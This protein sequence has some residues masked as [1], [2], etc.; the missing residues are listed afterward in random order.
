MN[1]IVIISLVIAVVVVGGLIWRWYSPQ[2]KQQVISAPKPPVVHQSPARH[3]AS[4]GTYFLL[5]RVALTTD[6]GVVCFAPGTKVNFAVRHDS[7][8]T[9]TVGEHKFD[10]A[11]SQLTNDLDIAA[12]VAKADYTAQVQISEL[13]ATQARQYAQQQRDAIAALEKENA[14]L[15]R[16]HRSTARAPNPLERGTY[17]ATQDTKYTDSSGRTYWKDV[18]KRTMILKSMWTRQTFLARCNPFC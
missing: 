9:V 11:S 3:L 1:R 6:S 13:T 5:Q 15:E 18:R 4:E 2:P 7:I 12:S 16:G 17:N 10:V 8:S 14:D